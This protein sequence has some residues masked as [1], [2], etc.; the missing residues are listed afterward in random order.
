[1]KFAVLA[2]A[3]VA[4]PLAAPAAPAPA[5]PV[6][7]RDL[8]AALGGRWTVSGELEPSPRTPDG[9]AIAGEEV[10]RSG[11]GGY[12]FSREERLVAPSGEIDGVVFIWW[13]PQ[14]NALRGLRCQSSDAQGCDADGVG[15]VS[16]RWNGKALTIDLASKTDPTQLA[17]REVFSD[18]TANG[19][20]Q[21]DYSGAANGLLT[22][23][24]TI[25]AVRQTPPL[26]PDK[27]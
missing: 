8:A 21:T 7:L 1:M 16:I 26:N 5:P 22:L 15:R 11:P 20:T 13:D 19:F 4:E 3:L 6:Q 12:S 23:S 17:R 14:A 18:I 27:E 2:L 24:L 9:G 10:W 25:H